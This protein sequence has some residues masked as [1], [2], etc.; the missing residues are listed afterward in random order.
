MTHPSQRNCPIAE[1]FLCRM[2]QKVNQFKMAELRAVLRTAK[3][4]SSGNKSRVLTSV[5]N[6]VIQSDKLA[7]EKINLIY[8]SNYAD[9]VRVPTSSMQ[10]RRL[11]PST[12]P[13]SYSQV[14]VRPGPTPGFQFRQHGYSMAELSPDVTSR[15]EPYEQIYFPTLLGKNI[16]TPFYDVLTCQPMPNSRE[17]RLITFR[18]TLSP[19]E[20]SKLMEESSLTTRVVF[21]VCMR[22]NNPI[23]D[24]VPRGICSFKV[25]GISIVLVQTP[26]KFEY[27]HTCRPIDITNQLNKDTHY[28]QNVEM[29]FLPNIDTVVSQWNVAI[30]MIQFDIPSLIDKL[31]V[32]PLA[33]TEKKIR[34][35]FKSDSE[36][37]VTTTSINFSLK[38]PLTG[39][40][41]QLPC[42]SSSCTHL[43]CFDGR[44]LVRMGV[45]T[46]KW[47]CP[48]CS[49]PAPYDTLLIDDYFR[50]IISGRKEYLS[51]IFLFEDG[52]WSPT[53][54]PTLSSPIQIILDCSNS[55]APPCTPPGSPSSS[56]HTI[57]SLLSIDIVKVPQKTNDISIIEIID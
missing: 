8:S 33:L 26:E 27:R 50:E 15:T 39:I 3:C 14:N 13:K 48:I 36:L 18:F 41:I 43:Q 29:Y 22:S 9:R 44:A 40:P 21:R 23:T 45:E 32:Y 19:S 46:E 16:S 7:I 30:E 1:A 20:V 49:T 31:P 34:Q 24:Q 55:S 28:I 12:S 5:K 53:S 10:D 17:K 11:A 2:M 42:R 6:L 4:N 25:N 35:A 54:K 52:H 57:C 38:C 37:S 56:Q 51:E 47:V